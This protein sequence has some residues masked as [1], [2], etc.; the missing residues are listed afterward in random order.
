MDLTRDGP[1]RTR[2]GPESAQ[3]SSLRDDSLENVPHFQ[4]LGSRL[5][6]DGSDEADVGHRLEITQSAFSSLSPLLADN[7]LSRTTKLRLSLTHCCEAWTL[8]R[9]VTRSINGF[10]SRC[11]TGEHYRDTA[12]VPAYDLVLVVRRRHLRY[13]GH[14][15]RMPADRMVRCVLMALVSDCVIYPTGSLFSDCQGV[16]LPQLVAM[17][18]NRAM[19][20]AKVASLS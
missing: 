6:G 3:G 7:R 11:L 8:N 15:L 19:W 13:L 12:T 9:T 14:V 16:A 18:S 2:T 17:A 10:N 1:E 5:Q 4:Y 20:R